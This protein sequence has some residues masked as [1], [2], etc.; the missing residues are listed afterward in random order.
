MVSACGWE[1]INRFESLA[2]YEQF[3][4]SINEQVAAGRVIALPLDPAKAWGNAWDEHW[5]QCVDDP[6]VWRLV[7]PDP[8]FRGIFKMVT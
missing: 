5:Y 8:P 1:P 3:L 6:A 2:H 4:S 7:G